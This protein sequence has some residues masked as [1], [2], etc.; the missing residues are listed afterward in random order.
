MSGPEI[1][2]IGLCSVA[3]CLAIGASTAPT[4]GADPVGDSIGRHAL[5]FGACF[6]VLLGWLGL[7]MGE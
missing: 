7:L 5:R 1:W 4:L 6:L 3:L 2:A